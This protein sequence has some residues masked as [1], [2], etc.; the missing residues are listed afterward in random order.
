MPLGKK[1]DAGKELT[2]RELL[3]MSSQKDSRNY[4]VMG[5]PAVRKPVGEKPAERREVIVI[6]TVTEAVPQ[7]QPKAPRVDVRI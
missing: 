6:N 1:A 5:D 4:A 3:I 2:S 7:P